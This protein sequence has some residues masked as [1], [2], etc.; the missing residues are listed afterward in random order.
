V[1][2][3]T[4]AQRGGGGRSDG[5]GASV[6]PC[7]PIRGGA[8]RFQQENRRQS[9]CISEHLEGVWRPGGPCR[10]RASGRNV[11]Q[12][13]QAPSRNSLRFPATDLFSLAAFKPCL[14]AWDSKESLQRQP[15]ASNLYPYALHSVRLGPAP[16]INAA[17][18][19]VPWPCHECRDC[20]SESTSHVEASRRCTSSV[21]RCQAADPLQLPSFFALVQAARRLR[22]APT[23]AEMQAGGLPSSRSRVCCAC[24]SDNVTLGGD[25][26]CRRQAW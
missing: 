3:A 7:P 14:Q 6:W 24:A 11:Q 16:W 15:Q 12:R 20:R 21:R 25:A 17:G 9:Q 10:G 19:A 5:P 1:N 2:F 23:S 18:Q 13:P 26:E 8:G 22:P 4:G